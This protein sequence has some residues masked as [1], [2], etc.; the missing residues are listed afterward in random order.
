MSKPVDEEAIDGVAVLELDG[1]L[2]LDEASFIA[3]PLPGVLLSLKEPG[4]QSRFLYKCYL[5]RVGG[6][7]SIMRT[8]TLPLYFSTSFYSKKCAFNFWCQ[9]CMKKV[10]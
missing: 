4:E 5:L 7:T 1:R 10:C 6:R 2:A 9:F 8:P 3:D